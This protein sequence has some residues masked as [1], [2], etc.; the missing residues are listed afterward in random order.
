M[1][2]YLL[3]SQ[4]KMVN[5]INE[6]EIA[7]LRHCNNHKCIISWKDKTLEMP[8]LEYY[9]QLSGNTL[10]EVGIFKSHWWIYVQ[11]MSNF[12]S[13]GYCQTKTWVT[14]AWLVGYDACSH[15]GLW[16]ACPMRGE[17]HE[18]DCVSRRWTA[19]LAPCS[20]TT[21]CKMSIHGYTL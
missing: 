12:V 15:H 8:S 4:H 7:S 5:N 10:W 1:N 13:A 20:H 3:R 17:R 6:D 21:S 14:F 9:K 19:P 11:D 2:V 18:C 16:D